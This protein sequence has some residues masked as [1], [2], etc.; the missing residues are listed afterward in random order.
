MLLDMVIPVVTQDLT[1]VAVAAEVPGV[2]ELLD[3]PIN[4]D[5]V[6]SEELMFMKP[7]ALNISLAEVEEPVTQVNPPVQDLMVEAEG[8]V[9]AHLITIRII[10]MGVLLMPQEEE[11]DRLMPFREALITMPILFMA[12]EEELV[13]TG[14]D[15]HNPDG[16]VKR[17]WV[18]LVIL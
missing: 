10:T 13:L 4:T 9:T 6:V 17:V 11:A 7:V 1:G 12:A 15:T 2:L 18:V 16:K 5:T 3:Q 8:T 14:L